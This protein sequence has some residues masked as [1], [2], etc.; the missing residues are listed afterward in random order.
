MRIRCR[1]VIVA[2]IWACLPNLVQAADAELE[3]VLSCM[4]ANIPKT[5]QIKDVE[6][7][8]TDRTGGKRTLRGRFY[9]TRE[10]ER[11]RATVKIVAPADLSGAAY[12]LRERPSGGDEMYVY[13]PALNKVRRVVGAAADGS[14]WGTDISYGDI[15]QLNNAF[16][17]G[18]TKLEPAAVL[19]GRAVHVLAATPTADQPSRFSLMRSWVDKKTCMVL[20]AEFIEGKTVRKRLLVD[21]KS[22]KQSGAHWYA[23]EAVMNDLQQGTRTELKV[24][25]VSVGG[26]LS[27]RYFN[28]AM[29]HV[30]S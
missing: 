4:R 6:L 23:G 21:P 9:G 19:D 22:L 30:G 28:P 20:K 7:I 13:V 12:L 5:V 11:L 15:K 27:D 2:A 3:G 17:G 14:L 25:G 10:D 24:L 29:F 8:A 18:N 16:S 1:T 26:E